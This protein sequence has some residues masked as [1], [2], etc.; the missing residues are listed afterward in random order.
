MSKRQLTFFAAFVI[1]LVGICLVVGQIANAKER[2][3]DRSPNV[4][5]GGALV[6]GT[7][8]DDSGHGYPLYARIDISGFPGSPVYTD[9]V[10]GAYQADLDPGVTYTFDVTAVSG[11]Y[12]VASREV[13]PPGGNSTENFDLV[14][15]ASCTAPGY[16]PGVGTGVFEEFES[17]D[18]PLGW[19]VV[20]NLG[21]GQVWEFVDTCF[22]GNNT[23][24]SGGFAMINSDCYGSSGSQD[25]ELRSPVMDLTGQA[26]VAIDFD[27]EFNWYDFGLDEKCD[28]DVS[29]D[30][31]GTWQNVLRLEDGDVLGPHHETL[32]ISGIAGNQPNV[33]VRF[34]FY[35][36]AFEFWWEVDNVD[37]GTGT[38]VPCEPVTGGLV[39]GNVLDLN[40]GAG[41]NGAT[42]SSVSAPS[43]STTTF[44]TPDDANNEDGAYILFSSITGSTDF[45]AT[46]NN[47]GSDTHTVNVAEDAATGQDFNLP[48]GNIETD[49]DSLEATVDLGNS[50]TLQLTL[51]NTGTADAEFKLT[52]ANGPVAP[53]AH[54]V[55]PRAKYK[56]PLDRAPGPFST[57][58]SDFDKLRKQFAAAAEKDKE[59]RRL[60]AQKAGASPE[61][62]IP[63]A[64]YPGGIVRGAQIQCDDQVDSIY[65]VSGVDSGGNIIDQVARYDVSTDTWTELAPIPIPN[66][67]MRGACAD[68]KLYVLG[69]DFS[70]SFAVYDIATDTWSSAADTPRPVWGAALGIFEGNLYMAGG[71]EDF[72]FGGVSDEVNIYNIAS[73]TWTGNGS[74]M[75]EGV[76][77]AGF[78]QLG[79]FLYVVGGWNNSS[80]GA[81]SHFTQRYDMSSDTWET[82]PEFTSGRADFALGRT[83]VALY[84][85]GGDADGGGPFDAT[86]LVE[87]LDTTAWPGGA[88]A[89]LGDPI[90]AP[91]T[92]NTHGSCTEGLTGGE[93]WSTG[94]AF[95]IGGTH[96]YRTTG[97][98][99][100]SS[101]VPWL[102][103]NPE[104]GIITAGNSV[105]VDVTLDA[106]VPEINQP[107]TYIAQIRVGEDTPGTVPPV[108]V[109]MNVPLPAGWG[110]LQGT[111]NALGRCDVPAGGLEGAT[112]FVD[113]AGVDWTLETDENGFY[114]V[115]FPAAD[116]PVTVTVSANGFVGQSVSGVVVTD[117]GTTDQNFDLRLDAPCG[118]KSPDSFDVTL[119]EGGS[120]TETLTLTNDGAGTFDFNIFESVFPLP[121]QIRRPTG[122][123]RKGA[124]QAAPS[125][126][127][128]VRSRQTVANLQT[129]AATASWFFGAPIP[130]GLVRYAHAQCDTQPGSFYVI[131]GVDGN[132]EISDKTWRYDAETNTW[133]ELAPIPEGQEG[134]AGACYQG[135]IYVTGG[136]GTDQFYIYDIAS[137]RWSSGATLPRLVWGPAVAA[138]D[139]KVY[140]IGG[141][142]DFFF[143]GTSNQVDI[144]DIATNTWTGTGTAMPSASVA[145]GYV[146]QANYIY[147]VGGWNDDSPGA[148][149]PVSQRYDTSTD[150]WTTGPNLNEARADLGVA[151]TENAIYALAGDDDGGGPFDSSSA[152]ERLDLAGWPGG[153]WED[154]GD[155]IP[156]P[157]S[158]NNG[159]FCTEELHVFGTLAEIWTPG[160]GNANGAIVGNNAFRPTNEHCFSIF[161]DVPWLEVTLPAGV[162]PVTGS[163]PPD[164]SLALNVHIT[165]AGLAPG[166]YTASIVITTNDPGAPQ[167]VIPVTLHVGAALF[168]DQFNDGVLDPNWKYK[169]NWSEGNGVVTVTSNN[170][171]A[172]A[173]A[174]PVFG[175]C[176][177]CTISTSASTSGG[178][179]GKLSFYG[180]WVSNKTNIE[181]QVKENVDKVTIRQKVNG[182]I[183]KKQSAPITIDPNTFYTITMTYNGT[184]IVVNIDGTDVLT[185]TP[186]GA[187]QMGTVGFLVKGTGA[188]DYVVAN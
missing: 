89:D 93:V 170:D 84:A 168:N 112:V 57:R 14:V 152:A 177:N 44:A 156:D 137:D 7:V 145:A 129:P 1:F 174:T 64:E 141:D 51:N 151:G 154:L 60:A 65:I 148:N 50:T 74:P 28:V 29:T 63:A 16:A 80:P 24:G 101:D 147:V 17:G 162:D 164:S 10:T 85:I 95:P 127:S 176:L 133:T 34:H 171:P 185:F 69:G 157:V 169:K 72:F 9:P 155:P 38:V 98:S 111:V 3:R 40:D 109:T 48:S 76:V 66:E 41:I 79:N 140:M 75:P 134:P 181:L 53:I 8:L 62:W 107:G 70:T 131:S 6:S 128:S 78:A 12:D 149:N 163:V 159:G 71:D 110:Y 179:N 124:A 19:T 130:G 104:E 18:V 20:D 36:A 165:T 86:D 135:Q 90:P 45:T 47:Y 92:A 56:A 158:S 82:G 166:D 42:V 83:T 55:L 58:H 153:A 173:I 73:D 5:A 52:E 33:M 15:S 61:A 183:K 160:G 187:V 119:G 23:G 22:I 97:E 37:I 122:D 96:Q 123:I 121:Q 184:D 132:F 105:V 59:Q 99:C 114:K 150:I 30:G 178:N 26:N 142:D 182:K 186:Q 2:N 39:V 118:S 115:A 88:W 100:T 46:A 136:G 102:F 67:G 143:G 35:E 106:S 13:T 25:T 167:F 11:G 94:G 27:M 139:G 188:F 43:E 126:P 108:Q 31:G 161:S 21:N 113:T 32:D 125:G 49:P 144:Y 103:E 4:G 77:T 120:T 180:W 138:W 175:G 87:R 116:S 91:L 68:G 146:Q 172:T 81:N 54:P 117:Q